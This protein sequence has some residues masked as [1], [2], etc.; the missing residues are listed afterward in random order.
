LGLDI[1]QKNAFLSQCYVEKPI[2]QD[3]LGTN[4]HRETLEK[5]AFFL[6]EFNEPMG[7]LQFPLRFSHFYIKMMI[8]PRQARDKHRENSKKDAV[9]GTGMIQSPGSAGQALHGR[10]YAFQVRAVLNGV[11][12]SKA[13]TAALRCYLGIYYAFPINR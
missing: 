10:P 8:L 7:T 1:G 5:E 2:Y 9:F 11:T 13:N 12:P 4:K 3:R 6:R